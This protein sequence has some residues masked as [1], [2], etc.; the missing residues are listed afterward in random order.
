MYPQH[1]TCNNIKDNM[2]KTIKSNKNM[3][4]GVLPPSPYWVPQSHVQWKPSVVSFHKEQQRWGLWILGSEKWRGHPLHS[5]I[6]PRGVEHESYTLH[7]KQEG[8]GTDGDLPG[9]PLAPTG[10][11]SA[12]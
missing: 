7:Q 9:P 5:R 6:Y 4:Q 2:I 3:Y 1:K 12:R 8:G 10:V 11:F